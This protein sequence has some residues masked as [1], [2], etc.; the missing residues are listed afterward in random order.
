[1]KTTHVECGFLPLVDSAPL[2]IAKELKFAAEEGLDLSLVRQPSW[3]ALRDM[4]ALGHLDFAHMLAPMPIA[5]SLGLGGMPA[6]IDA[7]MVLSVNGTV[8]GVSA[9]LNDQMQNAGWTNSFDNPR[10]T[11][12]ALFGARSKP[13][14]IGV[15]FPFSM[16]RLLLDYWLTRDPDF[17][18]DLVEIITVPPPRMATALKVGTLDM[19]CVGEPWGSV[20]VQQSDA[21]LVLPGR[22][23]W[24]F[25]P[26]KI[27]GARHT[28]VHE[29]PNTCHAMIRAV[30]KAARWLEQPQNTPLAVE[31]LARS[32]HLGLPDHAIDPALSGDIRLKHTGALKQTE[33]FVRFHSG[34]ANFP[35]RSQASWIAQYLAKLHDLDP[36]NVDAPARKCFRSDLYRDALIPLGADLP[37]A[38]EKI[39]GALAHPTAV[40]STRG[41]MIL[42]PDRFFDGARFD[43]HVQFPPKV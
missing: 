7:L 16:H 9:D 10:E 25:A 14:R 39:E 6:Q 3:S 13:L 28:W 29:N 36:S 37:G 22:A 31:I 33:G 30:Y 5:M 12:A 24:E 2:I 23:I 19:F 11:A 8:I 18:P 38:S 41:E 26:E 15:P 4:L 43:N 32:Q 20:A 17:Q 42:G 1:M 40:A 35:W 27:L 21:V 34:A